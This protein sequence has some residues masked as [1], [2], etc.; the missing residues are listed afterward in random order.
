M[1][2]LM[3]HGACERSDKIQNIKVW[4]RSQTVSANTYEISVVCCRTCST[5]DLGGKLYVSLITAIEVWV[6]SVS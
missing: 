6:D 1:I 5:Y 2:Y 4:A 3:Y